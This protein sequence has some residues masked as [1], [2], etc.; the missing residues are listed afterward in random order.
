MIGGRPRSRLGLE[1]MMKTGLALATLPLLLMGGPALAVGDPPVKLDQRQAA[2]FY[3]SVRFLLGADGPVCPAGQVP[4]SGLITGG[5]QPTGGSSTTTILFS[6][7]ARMKVVRQWQKPLEK[8][9]VTVRIDC[10]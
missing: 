4:L 3:A 10:S 9:S 8:L 2:A 7:G 6:K 5:A 1:L